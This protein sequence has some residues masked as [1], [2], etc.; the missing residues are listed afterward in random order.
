MSAPIDPQT[1]P[2]CHTSGRVETRATRDQRRGA[3]RLSGGRYRNDGG[4][5]MRF[6]FHTSRV[7]VG[8]LQHLQECTHCGVRWIYEWFRYAE[9]HAFVRGALAGPGGCAQCN[10]PHRII[11]HRDTVEC[12]LCGLRVAVNAAERSDALL[13]T[14]SDDERAQL[15]EAARVAAVA[16]A[17]FD[18]M[19]ADALREKGAA[20]WTEEERAFMQGRASAGVAEDAR[21][22]PL[23]PSAVSAGA[24]GAGG[25]P[26]RLTGSPPGTA[27]DDRTRHD[28][29][30]P[31]TNRATAEGEPRD[32]ML[33][34][35][36]FPARPPASTDIMR[37][38]V[39]LEDGDP[40]G[41]EEQRGLAAALVASWVAHAR[42][43]RDVEEARGE[44]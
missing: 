33:L 11:T 35:A 15:L 16:Q 40:L 12:A 5:D 4:W 24:A 22:A 38:I 21:G 13:A 42:L 30:M 23:P 3:T 2:A 9:H 7:E 41:L 43:Q 31:R 28:H 25:D 26:D 29:P 37:W 14:W 8:S 10:H 36:P 17:R 44:R 32:P 20:R 34:Q 27:T 1:C 6:N 39:R 19:R 18:A